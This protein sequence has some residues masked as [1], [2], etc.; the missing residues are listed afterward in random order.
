MKRL[1]LASF[2]SLVVAAIGIAQQ[3]EKKI[4]I[5][6]NRT[7]ASSGKQMY[8]SYCAPCH[9]MNG[10]GHGPVATALKTPPTD[11]TLLSKQH[12]GKFPDIH[13]VAVLQFG[14][15]TP[16]HGNADMPVW[17]P[18]LGKM[19]QANSQESQLRVS[20]LSSYL[21]SIQVK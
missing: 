18:I 8:G 6:V 14:V 21:K 10:K 15:D 12:D 13:I 2:A 3:P 1:L 7:Q 20:N 17:G 19:N 4:T 11:L 5:P 16:A 9:G